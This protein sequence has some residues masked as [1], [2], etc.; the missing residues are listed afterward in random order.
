MLDIYEDLGET[1]RRLILGALRCGSKNVSQ[2]VDVTRLKQ[3]NVSNHLARMRAKGVVADAKIGRQVYYSLATP[4]IEAIVNAVLTPHPPGWADLD[5]VTLAH[6]Y[7][8]AAV[9]GDESACSEILDEAFRAKACLLDIYQDLLG[10]AMGLVGN[11]YK[12]GEI[13]EAQEH[14]AS[15]ITERMTARTSQIAGP[16][17]RLGKTA[18]LGAAPNCWHCIGLRMISDLLRLRGWKT[19]YLGANVPA[20]S[21]LTT[22]EMADPD[23][24]L[25]SCAAD[26]GS[27][28]TLDLIRRLA[29]VRND[30]ARFMIGA[31][32][33]AVQ[34][35]EN[36]FQSAGV[37][38]IAKDI[39]SFAETRLPALEATRK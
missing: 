16:A 33:L 35:D 31:G 37:D 27:G 22:V 26:E 29:M 23:L 11:W 24:V 4:E 2:I 20:E 15:A 32:G 18:I 39:K 13:G 38:F 19:M 34:H 1:S 9:K 36:A 10:A 6:S 3:P 7:A 14:M 21:F 8:V 28:E 30:G 17:R 25:L 12:S 5:F